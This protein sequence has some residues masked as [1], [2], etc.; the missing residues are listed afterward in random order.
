MKAIRV[1]EFGGPEVLRLE[2]VPDPQAAAGQV[3]VR[4]RAAGVNP[5][6]TYIRGGVH[7]VKPQLP[8]TPG[9][10]A[11]GE[12]E[13][14]GE[15]VTRLHVG[16]RVY[17]AGS[18]TGTY[19]ELAL[20]E[21]AQ[22]HAL[23]ERVSFA[24][25]AGVFT[26]YATAYRALFQ[27]AGGRPGETVLVHGASGGVGTA[28]VQLARAAGFNIIGT[29]GTEEGR[30]LVAEQGAQHVLDH[31]APDYL[32]QLSTITGGR[33]VDVILEMLANVNLNKDLGV[34]AKGGRVVVIGSRGAVEIN[35]RLLMSRDG[36]VLGMSLFNA[37]PQ[38]LA[39]VH[40]ALAKGLETGTLRPVVGRELPLRE[41]ARAHEEVLKPG[42]YGKIV[43][44]P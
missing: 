18:L 19:A 28:A 23:P 16:Q 42:A 17:T 5:V 13:A 1:Q 21:E 32:E 22:A 6:D 29:G 7:A 38:E 27:R 2:D 26:P 37:S 9:L 43:L 33:G 41:A 39:S 3:V 30:K 34:L 15:G 4:V 10:D 24:E 8:F 40:A 14:V 25:G 11:A 31:H 36:V 44:V 20:C 12:V 35:P